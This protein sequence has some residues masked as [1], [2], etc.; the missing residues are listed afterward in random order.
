MTAFFAPLPALPSLI[1]RACLACNGQARYT[2]GDGYTEVACHKCGGTGTAEVCEGCGTVPDP[3][4]DA[5]LCNLPPVLRF[6]VEAGWLSL[7]EAA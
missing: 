1:S 5:C 7:E 3:I 6:G 2:V 4:T